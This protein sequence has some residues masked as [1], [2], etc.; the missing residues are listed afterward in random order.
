MTGSSKAA[1]SLTVLARLA[2][3][4]RGH[5]L[6]ERAWKPEDEP[7]W[8]DDKA[9]VQQTRSRLADVTIS[10]IVLTLGV[11]LPYHSEIDHATLCEIIIGSIILI[12]QLV[13]IS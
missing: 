13:R 3:K 8:L 7:D 2:E 9:S 12:R 11:S 10:T 6:T 4:Q 1:K 5:R